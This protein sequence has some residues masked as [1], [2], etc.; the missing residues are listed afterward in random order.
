MIENEKS[1]KA[2]DKSDERW[3]SGGKGEN[4]D[5]SQAE[6]LQVGNTEKGREMEM[7]G[8]MK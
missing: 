5:E 1:G 2:E 4:K 7:K 6:R 3:Q 8:E